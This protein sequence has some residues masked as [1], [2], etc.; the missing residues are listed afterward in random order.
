MI[1]ATEPQMLFHDNNFDDDFL[2]HSLDPKEDYN[3]MSNDALTVISD[4]SLPD[5]M[6]DNN[7]ADSE[8]LESD[9]VGLVTPAKCTSY[10][11]PEKVENKM[12]TTVIITQKENTLPAQAE[13]EPSPFD[14]LCGQ[15]RTCANHTGNKRFQSVLE[16]YAAKYEAA[17]KKQEKML[18]TKEIVACV[19]AS[20]G[21]FLKLKDGKWTKIANV[22]A[23][24]KVSHALRTKAQSWRRR[25]AKKSTGA[26]KKR[27]SVRKCRRTSAPQPDLSPINYVSFDGSTASSTSVMDEL[28]RTQREIFEKLT[29]SNGMHPLK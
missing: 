3:N 22:T 9:N 2:L 7:F 14:V 29:Q 28:L 27:P 26:P 11:T 15:S 23:R 18:F 4:G 17:E 8:F 16:I 6:D 5:L 19:A 24:D 13:D 10:N 21:R 25:Q 20:G 12:P 1:P